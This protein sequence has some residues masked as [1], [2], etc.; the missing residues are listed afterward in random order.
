MKSALGVVRVRLAEVADIPALP[1]IE[2]AAAQAFRAT[3]HAWV[4]DDGVTDA[5]EYPPLIADAAVWVAED[6]GVLAGFVSAMPMGEGLHVLELAVHTDHQRRGIGRSLMLAAISAARTRGYAAVTLT[7][8]RGV[9]FNAPFYRALDFEI[10]TD[11]P[12]YL[13]AILVNEA[14]RRLADRCAMRL[15]LA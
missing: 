9:V 10:L 3:D 1:A 6:K 5:S 2:R 7:T 4:A 13:H 12:P 15:A 14:E 11:P 8:F